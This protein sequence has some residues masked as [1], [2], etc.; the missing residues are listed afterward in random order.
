MVR[1]IS[2]YISADDLA[3]T[4]DWQSFCGSMSALLMGIIIGGL[5]PFWLLAMLTGIF[6]IAVLALLV[7]PFRKYAHYVAYSFFFLAFTWLYFS[8]F[9]LKQVF[10][11]LLRV[12]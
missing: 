4:L 10:A 1:G 6:F 3:A 7:R 8:I 11:F 12:L 9:N 2:K 5:I